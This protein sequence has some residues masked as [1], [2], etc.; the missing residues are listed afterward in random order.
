MTSRS[1]NDNHAQAARHRA[2]NKNPGNALT[3]DMRMLSAVRDYREQI[4]F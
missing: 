3:K 4:C 2:K 1:Q